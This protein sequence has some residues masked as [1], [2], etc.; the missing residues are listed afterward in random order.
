MFC[1]RV[2]QISSRVR[3]DDFGVPQARA[4]LYSEL[5]SRAEALA[6]PLARL[7]YPLP[8]GFNIEPQ[9][10]GPFAHRNFLYTMMVTEHP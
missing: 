7:L 4:V 5:F 8:C 6:E 1:F 10:G 9:K 3:K 2:E